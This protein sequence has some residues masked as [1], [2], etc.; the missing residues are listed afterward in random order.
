MGHPVSFFGAGIDLSD[1][2]QGMLTL[3]S[4]DTSD[5]LTHRFMLGDGK[6]TDTEGL[7]WWGTSLVQA[8]DAE[9]AVGGVA[10]SGS[11]TLS[12]FEDPDAGGSLIGEVRALGLD[13]VKGQAVRFYAQPLRDPSEFFAPTLAKRIYMTRTATG[14]DF[15]FDGPL[16]RSITLEF[17]GVFS[18]RNTARR[19]QYTTTDH[20]ALTG[21]ANPSLEFAPKETDL[22]GPLFG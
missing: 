3:V 11:L 13:Y 5:G 4:I 15:G 6:F 8:G 19:R 14:L 18:N 7:T 1:E 10:P 21:A 9:I 22:E 16:Q 20:A 17:E 2:V 12:F